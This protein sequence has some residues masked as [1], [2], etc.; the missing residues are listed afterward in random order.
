MAFVIVS[1]QML[2]TDT[3]Q[4]SV[5]LLSRITSQLDHTVPPLHELHHTALTPPSDPRFYSHQIHA[6]T[7]IRWINIPWFLSL[8]FSLASALFGILAKQ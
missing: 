7:A 1:Y 6:S 8:A 3:S 2:Q 4:T 5:Q